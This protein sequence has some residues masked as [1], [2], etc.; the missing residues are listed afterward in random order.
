MLS[1]YLFD[2]CFFLYRPL[3]FTYKRISDRHI[4]N[5][6]EKTIRPGMIV[7]DVGANI[8]FY[9]KV[10]SRLVG[11]AGEVHA[12]EPDPINFKRLQKNLSGFKN[13]VLNSMACASKDTGIK[14]YRSKNLNI[15]HHCF[16]TEE[17]RDAVE[18][19][20][21]CL[22]NYFSNLGKSPN[23]V[24]IDVQGFDFSA[25]SGLRQVIKKSRDIKILGELYPYGLRR[26]GSSPQEYLSFF[27]ENRM[28][29]DLFSS[30]DVESDDRFEY[31]DFLASAK[32]LD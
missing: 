1:S 11:P 21:V 4:L 12:F 16:E 26:A 2:H 27:T 10:L 19:K 20:A 7:V 18:V 28:D 8:G 3:Y 32:V 30:I 17:Q 6:L 25:I 31:T 24:K 23:F 14:L 5:L 15:D 22:D 13:V 9:S 29:V